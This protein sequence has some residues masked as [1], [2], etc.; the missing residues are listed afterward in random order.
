MTSI[1]SVR[2][3][4]DCRA[5]APH[6]LCLLGSHEAHPPS[7]LDPQLPAI[8]S[9]PCCTHLLWTE[10]AIYLSAPTPRL[11]ELLGKPPTLRTW[12]AGQ[13][14]PAPSWLTE[15]PPQPPPG[16]LS[17]GIRGIQ[18]ATS[19]LSPALPQGCAGLSLSLRRKALR[20]PHPSAPECAPV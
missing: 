8:P 6:P 20:P 18:V 12:S 13:V 9:A 11:P 5:P 15:P 17:G 1:A 14:L 19:S 16:S 3:P 2:G 10:S 7:H 4:Q